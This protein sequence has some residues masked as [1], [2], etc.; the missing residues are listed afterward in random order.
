MLRF[1]D[2][3]T[4]PS[5]KNKHWVRIQCQCFLR[6]LLRSLAAWAL[7]DAGG[8]GAWLTCQ[9]SW[10]SCSSQDCIPHMLNS[11]LSSSHSGDNVTPLH[12]VQNSTEQKRNHKIP[13]CI[14]EVPQHGRNMKISLGQKGSRTVVL[15]MWIF[16]NLLEMHNL[17]LYSRPADT[18][19]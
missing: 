17:G 6:I 13:G 12:A 10:A 3:A 2:G 7:W 19:G 9:V 5:L 4:I 14:R 11:P 8:R 1:L 16:R 18:L 15:K